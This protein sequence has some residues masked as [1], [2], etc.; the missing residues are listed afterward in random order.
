MAKKL[1][2]AE[3]FA[4]SR[5]SGKCLEDLLAANPKRYREFK[6]EQLR[7]SLRTYLIVS[8]KRAQ[9]AAKIQQATRGR[10]DA[11]LDATHRSLA[12]GIAE[13]IRLDEEYEKRWDAIRAGL[14]AAGAPRKLTE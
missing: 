6:V 14:I 5:A 2:H 7:A 12:L 11:N 9:R 3:V 4:G 10:V 1:S 13:V 8:E